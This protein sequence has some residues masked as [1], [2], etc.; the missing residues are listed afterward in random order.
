MPGT[1][2][3]RAGRTLCALALPLLLALFPRHGGAQSIRG[4]VIGTDYDRPLVGAT[5]LLVDST[6]VP[7]DSVVADTAGRFLLDAP[8]AGTFIVY[9]AP[10][11]YLS[12]SNAVQLSAGDTAELR[13]EMPVVSA[14]AADVMRDVINREAAFQLPWEELCEEPVRPWEAGVLVGVSRN[15]TTMEPLPRAVVRLEPLEADAPGWPRTRIATETGAFWFCNVPPGRVRAVARADGFA[16]DTWNAII[17]AG[18][19]SWYDALLR[20]GPRR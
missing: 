20:P 1:G 3:W 4:T 10:P 16:V 15:R 14:A 19:V 7:V 2:P 18:T 8:A 11:G 13:I 12:S 6:S 17:R 5:V 9:V